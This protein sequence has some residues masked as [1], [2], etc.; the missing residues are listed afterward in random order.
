MHGR[1]TEREKE[2]KKERRKEKE[3]RGE[4]ERE[5]ITASKESTNSLN[6]RKVTRER[7]A[8]LKVRVGKSCLIRPLV[9]LMMFGRS[10]MMRGGRERE[11][12]GESDEKDTI[13]PVN[14]ERIEM[15]ED[16]VNG[17]RA[18]LGTNRMNPEGGSTVLKDDEEEG[19]RER[20]A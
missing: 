14:R 20:E 7:A 10:V 8:I 17:R 15:R 18:N 4:R 9:V 3:G 5:R 2:T 6:P 13:Q 11:R 12:E 19:E 16:D 1:E